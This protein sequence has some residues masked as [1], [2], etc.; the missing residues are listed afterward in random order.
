LPDTTEIALGVDQFAD[1]DQPTVDARHPD[2]VDPGKPECDHEAGIDRAGE[3]HFGGGH[4]SLVADA[5]A[6]DKPWFTAQRLLDLADFFAP[7]VHNDRLG[8][9]RSNGRHQSLHKGR[10]VDVVPTYFDDT[11]C[12]QCD[13]FLA[14]FGQV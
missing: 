6:G 10:I 12:G 9:H 7:A 1:T 13:T 4:G 2:G 3:D 14:L 8:L 5:Q 11:E